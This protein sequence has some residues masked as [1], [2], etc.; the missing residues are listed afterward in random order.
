MRI[1]MRCLEK[2]V[3]RRY[4]SFGEVK[5]GLIAFGQ[6][7]GGERNNLEP[8]VKLALSGGGEEE[9]SDAKFT[10]MTALKPPPTILVLPFDVIT[11]NEEGSYL[12]VGLAHALRTSL[13]RIGGLSIIS[14]MAGAE[15]MEKQGGGIS[16]MA[17]E[18]GATIVLEGEVI[19]AEQAI[20][21]MVR[22]TDVDDGRVIWGGQY[23]S[24][25]KDF[26]GIQ[27]ELCK[28]IADGLKVRILSDAQVNI[29]RLT[30]VNIDAFELYSK[31]RELIDRRD[32]KENIDS[33]IHLF[34]RAIKLSP[35]F[36]LAQAGLCEAY[37]MKYYQVTRDNAWVE[38]AIAAGDRALV[39]D[40]RQAQVH[41]SL[42]I[43][44]NGTGKIE[45]AIESFEQAARLHPMND[46]AYRWLGR[47]YQRKGDLETAVQ[48][49]TKAIEIRPSYWENYYFL[50]ICYYLFGRYQDAA[51][52]FRR[53][54]T[55]QPD[56]YHGYDKLG[57][58]Y[59]LLGRY[60]DA[61]IMHKR[62]LEVTPSFESYSNL[63]TALFHLGHYEEALD[64]YRKAVGLNPR[65]DVM[66]RNLG[67]AYLHVG[68][69]QYARAQYETACG[70]L[71]ERLAVERDQAELL[72]RL[73]VCR[74][75]LQRKDEAL[76]T[77]EQAVA[78]EPN[79][80]SL[81]YDRAVVLT[82]TGYADE[83]IDCLGQALSHGFSLSEV[84]RDPDLKTLHSE[85]RYQS[86]ISAMSANRKDDALT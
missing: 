64:A 67:D 29:S 54:I 1:A 14:K 79:N 34:E 86:L 72:G 13:A 74:A 37:W 45:R 4:S 15:R 60:E 44:Y 21:V 83:A 6:D 32:I 9:P 41:I 8:T 80:T 71:E 68:E 84:E 73:A 35:E 28:G 75:K 58:I 18:L 69:G 85:A 62:A 31:G 2:N 52:Q 19:R 17:R 61:V 16:E 47:C 49:F 12:G 26:F 46:A 53:L 20:H 7:R 51:E 11:S 40:P 27:D 25:I 23:Q 66:R 38:R 70:L 3:S 55:I 63:G 59:I 5:L 22:L 24:D 78:L 76:R 81:M 50:G 57:A 39:L 56:S 10:P 48:R 65:D 77:I 33:A 30:T 36:A 43:I 82:L 42:G